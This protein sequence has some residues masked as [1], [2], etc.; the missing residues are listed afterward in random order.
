MTGVIYARYSSDN[1]REESIEGQ[2][3]ECTAFAQKN[4]ITI[5]EHYIDRAYS[6]KTD[7]RPEFQRMIRESAR[8]A[9]DVVIVWKLDRFSRN[10]FDSA[11]YKAALK[12][13]K[14]R[15]VSATE[16]ISDG[17]EGIIL[18]SVLEGMA[19]YYSADLSEKVTRGHTENALKCQFNG[20]V[21][22]YGYVIDKEKHYQLDLEKAPIVLEIFKR[23]TSGE[24]ITAIIKDL[25]A[26][27]LR[28]AKGNEFNKNSLH[29][30]LK[31][32]NYIGEYRYKDFVTPGGVPAIVPEDI[33]NRAV[34][35]ME[36]NKHAPARKKAKEDYL[37]TTKLFCG[38]CLAMMI[39]ESGQKSNGNIYRYYKCAGAK[40][41]V[42]DKKTVRKEWIEDIALQLTMKILMSDEDLQKIADR[43]MEL[44]KSENTLIPALERQLED[45]RASIDNIL[46]AIEMGVCTRSTKSR[47]EE[48]EAKEER[49]KRDICREQLDSRLVTEDQIWYIFDK[50]RQMDLSM[51]KQRQRLIDSFLQSIV[52][53]DDRLIISFNYRSQPVTIMLDQLV[54]FINGSGSDLVSAASPSTKKDC[55]KGAS[56]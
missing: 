27:G 36:S 35:L 10:R 51:P 55:H 19:E 52:L 33:F 54:D 4:D 44:Q 3:R 20:S 53:F 24:T 16:A 43:I 45:V 23:Y 47:L 46:K 56:R 6:A 40:K 21:V 7:N 13:N 37:L 31:N 2:L 17:A 30:M 49:I 34:A 8:K 15:V 29:H 25:N 28:T 39:G 12:K 42:C 32:R 1:Q 5:I 18:E 14:I 11:K 48:L 50:F 38:N 26:R 41:H 22:P 9:Y